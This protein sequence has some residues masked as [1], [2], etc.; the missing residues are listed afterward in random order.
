MVVGLKLPMPLVKWLALEGALNTNSD[1]CGFEQRYMVI[2]S[3]SGS[4]HRLCFPQLC[5]YG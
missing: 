5:G 4:S 3:L 2:I 1:H